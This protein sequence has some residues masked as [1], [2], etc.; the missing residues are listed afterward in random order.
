MQNSLE[1]QT[2]SVNDMLC[3]FIICCKSGTVDMTVQK[4]TRLSLLRGIL[5][6]VEFCKRKKKSDFQ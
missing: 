3:K 1:L 6:R 5:H 4:R 2:E